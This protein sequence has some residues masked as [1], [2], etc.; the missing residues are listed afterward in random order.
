MDSNTILIMVLG[1][2][3]FMV[4]FFVKSYF[5]G[6]KKDIKKLFDLIEKR[7]VKCIEHGERITRVEAKTNGWHK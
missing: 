6:I 2:L 7:D 4:C 3:Q 1:A 5:S